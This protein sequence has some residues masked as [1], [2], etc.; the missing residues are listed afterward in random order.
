[1]ELVHTQIAFMEHIDVFIYKV[2]NKN[3][4]FPCLPE[5]F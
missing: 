1:M 2:I 4:H 3:T 5:L